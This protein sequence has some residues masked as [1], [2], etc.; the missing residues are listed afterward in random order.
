ME[1]YINFNGLPS[2]LA[3]A[4]L[5][6]IVAETGVVLHWRPMLGNLGNVAGGNLKPGEADPL[7]AYR[8]RRGKARAAAKARELERMCQTLGI[9]PEAGGRTIDPVALSLGLNRVVSLA[10]PEDQLAY[11]EAAFKRAYRESAD[12]E[13]IA[14]VAGLMDSLGISTDGFAEF[15]ERE[16]AALLASR[17]ELL[18]KSILNAPAFVLDEEVFNGREHL[19]LI[20]WILKGRRGTPP[21]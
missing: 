10:S 16:E 8:E 5:R 13:T 20:E 2:W 4:P 6:R 7:S 15:C 18:N 17:D 9:D 19:P 12:V 3:L 21:V 11:L 14:A 1:V